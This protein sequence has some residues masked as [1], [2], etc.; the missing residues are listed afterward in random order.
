M[1]D[2]GFHMYMYITTIITLLTVVNIPKQILIQLQ[3]MIKLM[4]KQT[5]SILNTVVTLL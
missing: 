1:H 4:E 5:S 2:F 3:Y